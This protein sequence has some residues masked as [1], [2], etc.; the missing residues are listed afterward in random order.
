MLTRNTLFDWWEPVSLRKPVKSTSCQHR[1]VSKS[2]LI[3]I[4]GAMCCSNERHDLGLELCV[5]R[6]S[7]HACSDRPAS[8]WPWAQY[9]FEERGKCA[10]NPR[11]SYLSLRWGCQFSER[12][13]ETEWSNG[14][15]TRE[16]R[17]GSFASV[18]N[19]E[20]LLNVQASG[21]NLLGFR[22]RQTAYQP[23]IKSTDGKDEL[24]KFTKSRTSHLL[25]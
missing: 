22:A 5:Q 25:V 20:A 13:E 16:P 14:I 21:L 12:Q 23:R 3:I 18:T 10:A 7:R 24:G 6:V 9:L 19:F 17:L 15:W 11:S 8:Q 4:M 1:L 2:W